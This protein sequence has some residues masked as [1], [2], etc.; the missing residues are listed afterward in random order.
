MVGVDQLWM[1]LSSSCSVIVIAPLCLII[2]DM[3]PHRSDVRTLMS[4]DSIST[5]LTGYQG[6]QLIF[7]L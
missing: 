5:R 4:L 3:F 1:D 2:L 7:L 6:D